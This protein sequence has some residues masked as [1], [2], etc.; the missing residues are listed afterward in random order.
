MRLHS[1]LRRR[2]SASIV[3]SSTALFLS[4]GGVGYAA[5]TI[6]ANSVD[7]A[8]IRNGA[9]TY[10]KIAPNSVGKIRL[11]T[12]GVTNA[13]LAKNSVSYKDIQAGAVG[14][15]RAN[16]NQ[17][18]ARLKTAC[19]AGTAVGTVDSKGN[20][21]C[22]TTL[23]SEYDTTA[24]STAVTGTA[25]PVASLTL[26]AGPNY[27][28]FAN[29]EITRHLG[30]DRRARD[31]QLHADRRQ[32]HSDPQRDP[33]RARHLGPDRGGQPA[34]AARRRRRRVVGRLHGL[35]A[36]RLDAARDHRHRRDQRAGHRHHHGGDHHDPHAD[37]DDH[38]HHHRR[39]SAGVATGPPPR[40]SPV[41]T[42]RPGRRVPDR[43]G[44]P[45]SS[46]PAV[47][48]RVRA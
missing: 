32:Q 8:A 3:I 14:T 25:A 12:G 5:T 7:S 1:L 39:A 17:L 2:P 31:R 48:C 33:R 22:N 13:K 40:R 27:L 23:P 36:D 26:A 18:Q 16:L 46:I 47:R 9:V 10:K 15:V 35:G 38:H 29:P 43:V 11:A 45:G 24:S 44:A 21:T 28:V 42:R 4:L 20:V 34:T 41:G 6:G 37:H 19:A 30:R